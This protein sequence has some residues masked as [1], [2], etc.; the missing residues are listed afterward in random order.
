MLNR[1]TFL[2]NS[3][4]VI[5][6]T[7]TLNALDPAS[8]TSAEEVA[9]A[10]VSGSTPQLVLLPPR[11]IEVGTHSAWVQDV[12]TEWGHEVLV[13]NPRLIRFS[14]LAALM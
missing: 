1:R 9:A 7:A 10:A 13:A 3:A 8:T 6:M 11:M 5:P 12:I 14:P 4:A 2:K